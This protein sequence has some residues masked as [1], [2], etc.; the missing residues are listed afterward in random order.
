MTN[1]VSNTNATI[2]NTEMDFT[3][4]HIN[5]LTK[6]FMFNYIIN[7]APNQKAWFKKLVTEE[8]VVTRRTRSGEVKEIKQPQTF[9]EVR[10]QFAMKFFPYL[11]E[12]RKLTLAEMVAN[13]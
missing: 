12:E 2:N 3:V 1:L 13:W 9:A 6:D 11:I 7:K 8:V 5:D 4:E 10:K